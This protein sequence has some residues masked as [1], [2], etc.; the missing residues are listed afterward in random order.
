MIGTNENI[1]SKNTNMPEDINNNVDNG[2]KVRLKW[3]LHGVKLAQ[4]SAPKTALARPFIKQ[5]II[6][7][8]L[9]GS[10]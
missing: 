6:S 10:S 2:L 7:F 4:T 8:K 3:D 1:M 9:K 5:Q